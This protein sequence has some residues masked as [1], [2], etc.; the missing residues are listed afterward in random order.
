MKCIVTDMKIMFTFI[1]SFFFLQI[2]KCLACIWGKCILK[3]A[4]F[5]FN[6]FFITIE[7]HISIMY[8]KDMEEG[9]SFGG[10]PFLNQV[11]PREV[12]I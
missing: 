2:T 9:G 5:V 3:K 12:K 8:G 6:S 11:K 1:A 4:Q 10:R 7:H